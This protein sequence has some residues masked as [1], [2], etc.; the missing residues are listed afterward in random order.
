MNNRNIASLLAI[1]CGTL[2]GA[3]LGMFAHGPDAWI[4]TA[5]VC[6][7]GACITLSEMAP[8]F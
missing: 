5:A 2:F 7:V 8:S 1:V 4:G 3:S 6:A